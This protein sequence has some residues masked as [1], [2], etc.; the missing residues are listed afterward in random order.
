MITNQTRQL[1]DR[2][3]ILLPDGVI[4]EVLLSDSSVCTS[5]YQA[6]FDTVSCVFEVWQVY[7]PECDKYL[8][9]R[10][11]DACEDCLVDSCEGVFINRFDAIIR[12][13]E[14]KP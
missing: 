9:E 6:G 14:L 4:L 13:E 8:Y 5:C 1:L 10:Q 7:S 3:Y 11:P 12:W 2:P